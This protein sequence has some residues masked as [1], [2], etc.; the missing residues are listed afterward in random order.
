MEC[1][2][3]KENI[4]ILINKTTNSMKYDEY[5]KTIKL[6]LDSFQLIDSETNL[7]PLIR[8]LLGF[9]HNVALDTRA[10]ISLR[11]RP[12]QRQVVF[13]HVSDTQGLWRAWGSWNIHNS[14]H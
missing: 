11:G 14:G 3:I 10:S 7:L 4:H 1:W 8:S 9:L 13:P 2:C 6:C 5:S 12:L